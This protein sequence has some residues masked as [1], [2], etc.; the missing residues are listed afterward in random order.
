M[1]VKVMEK[2][3]LNYFCYHRTASVV[4]LVP[5]Y[6]HRPHRRLHT[7]SLPLHSFCDQKQKCCGVTVLGGA[8]CRGLQG[9]AARLSSIWTCCRR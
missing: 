2:L 5:L 1:G 7:K 8:V 9:K 6:P 4:A 3:H